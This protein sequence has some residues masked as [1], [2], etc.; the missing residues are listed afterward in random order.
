MTDYTLTPRGIKNILKAEIEAHFNNLFSVVHAAY[1][2]DVQKEI[3]Y[4]AKIDYLARL[5]MCND[6][7]SI[8]KFISW[9]GYRMSLEDWIKSL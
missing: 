9:A 1:P 6:Y 2:P 7:E 4:N 5:D 3:L 8:D